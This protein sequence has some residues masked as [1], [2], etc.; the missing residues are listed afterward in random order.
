LDSLRGLI[1]SYF[2]GLIK[3]AWWRWVAVT[4]WKE[5]SS[6]SLSVCLYRRCNQLVRETWFYWLSSIE[7][8]D[9]CTFVLD[10]MLT[11]FRRSCCALVFRKWVVMSE[12]SRLKQTLFMSIGRGKC[13]R[14]LLYVF[15]GWRKFV[16]SMREKDMHLQYALQL[17][18]K[19]SEMNVQSEELEALKAELDRQHRL[20][21]GARMRTCLNYISD[22]WLKQAWKRWYEG[23]RQLRKEER[24]RYAAMLVAKRNKIISLHIWDKWMTFG[25]ERQLGEVIW[26]CM[27]HIQNQAYLHGWNTWVKTTAA[28]R[29]KEHREALLGDGEL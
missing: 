22:H 14:W 2:G 12:D 24:R 16:L 27:I 21:M 20:R 19:A 13:K 11:T 5:Q 26:Y 1:Y 9:R 10:R 18:E 23:C 29:L 28:L 6:V 8:R 15:S 4:T 3:L 25:R 17:R 7:R